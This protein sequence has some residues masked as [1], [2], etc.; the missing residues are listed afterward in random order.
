MS[1]Y[2]MHLDSE[3]EAAVFKEALSLAEAWKLQDEYLLQQTEFL[4]LPQAFL[5]ILRKLQLSEMKF[6]GQEL[7]H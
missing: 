4:Q 7:L 6:E 5:P 1:A 3:L 2:L